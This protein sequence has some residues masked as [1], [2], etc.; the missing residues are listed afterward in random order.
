MTTFFYFSE[1]SLQLLLLQIILPGF[2]EQS[3]TRI[4]L[5]GLIRIW[6]TCVAWILDIKSY[7]LGTEPRPNEDE[8]R[9]AD[10]GGGLAAAHQALLQR[11]V[12]VG[13]QPYDRP[14]FFPIRVFLLLV[15]MAASL[16]VGSLLTLTIPVFIGRSSFL[17]WSKSTG[18]TAG[19]VVTYEGPITEVAAANELA[20]SKPHELYTAAIG[21]YLCWLISKGVALGVNLLPQG[22]TAIKEK[23]K[24]WFSVA[25]SYALA[26]FV[27]VLMLGLVPRK[28]LLIIIHSNSF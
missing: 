25:V 14:S 4:W 23:I 27:F 26:A 1:L 13:F 21:I 17:L 24:H 18:I 10:Q 19:K 16:V 9:Q 28:F 20:T 3:Q 8:P 22:R 15:F 5:K 2:F 11:D 6:C 7:L 12:P